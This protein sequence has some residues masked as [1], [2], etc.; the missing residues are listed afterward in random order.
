MIRRLLCGT[1]LLYPSCSV[2]VPGAR[3]CSNHMLRLQPSKDVVLMS[4]N[5]SDFELS[6]VASVAETGSS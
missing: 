1:M 4:A 5:L 3:R 6:G 2:A